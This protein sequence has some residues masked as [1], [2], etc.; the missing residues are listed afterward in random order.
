MVSVLVDYSFPVVNPIDQTVRIEGLHEPTSLLITDDGTALYCADAQ[1]HIIRRIELK[2]QFGCP[3]VGTV[4]TVCG[5]GYRFDKDGDALTTASI[6][7]TNY[8]C[9]KDV[10]LESAAA[11]AAEAK[12]Q[13]P[14]P[15]TPAEPVPAIATDVNRI[16]YVSTETAIRRFTLAC[17]ANYIVKRLWRSAGLVGVGSR[18]GSDP[19]YGNEWLPLIDL[20]FIIASFLSE[21]GFVDTI[22]LAPRDIKSPSPRGICDTP[23]GLLLVSTTSHGLYTV[24]P[25]KL[26]PTPFGPNFSSRDR[27]L[28]TDVNC[29]W[30]Q[31]KLNAVK[32]SADTRN[33]GTQ[34]A[35]AAHFFGHLTLDIPRRCVYVSEMYS[36]VLKIVLPPHL[37]ARPNRSQPPKPTLSQ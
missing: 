6:A 11:A 1:H 21:S 30:S 5:N 8:M 31:L 14:D 20:W 26:H 7:Y 12:S 23:S 13:G 32:K 17:D 9:W 37:F 29:A 4:T 3:A 25:T 24:D 33:D 36:S 2:K 28:S 19:N 18:T 34:L 16:M 15:S 27:I 35:P 10:S 22:Q